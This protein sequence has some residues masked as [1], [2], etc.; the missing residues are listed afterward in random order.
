MKQRH[1]QKVIVHVEIVATTT[2]TTMAQ[3]QEGKVVVKSLEVKIAEMQESLTDMA[4]REKELKRDHS[5]IVADV[6]ELR[7]EYLQDIDDLVAR[8]SVLEVDTAAQ[9]KRFNEKLRKVLLEA[10]M[11]IF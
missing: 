5:N 10:R 6:K 9:E 8:I 4:A 1:E 11:R 3:H 2:A 7:R